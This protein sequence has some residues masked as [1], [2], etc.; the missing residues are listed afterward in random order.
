MRQPKPKPRWAKAVWMYGGVESPSLG[1]AT[2]GI[3]ATAAI[4]LTLRFTMRTAPLASR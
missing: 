4:F 2:L 3:R 1:T